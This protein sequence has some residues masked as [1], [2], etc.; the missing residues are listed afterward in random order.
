MQPNKVLFESSF[1]YQ[2]TSSAMN[3]FTTTNHLS[4]TNSRNQDNQQFKNLEITL[5][6]NVYSDQI[7]KRSRPVNES[8]KKNN[9][10]PQGSCPFLF[11]SKSSVPVITFQNDA[12][13]IQNDYFY[14]SPTRESRNESIISTP[15]SINSILDENLQQ[16]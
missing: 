9:S 2:K 16:S 4:T 12:T 11:I 1:Q 10:E 13:V 15:E 6:P 8:E 7:P 14:G 5:F 3:N